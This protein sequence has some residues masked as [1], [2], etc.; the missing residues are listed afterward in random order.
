[1][2][3]TEEQRLDIIENCNRLLDGILKPFEPS[4]DTFEGRMIYQCRWL[5]ERAEN[6]DLPLPVDRGMLATLLYVYT[7]GELCNLATSTREVHAEAEVHMEKLIK[8]TKN[9]SLLLKPPY[10]PYAL[11][12]IEALRNVLHQ[13][14]RPLTQYEQGLIGELERL[15]QLLAEGKIEPPLMSYMPGYPN[16]IEVEGIE[17]ITIDDL[18]NG[19]QLYR[20]VAN[21]LFEGVRPETWFTLDNADLMTRGIRELWD[22][23]VMPRQ[24]TP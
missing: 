5:K 22:S 19:K 7:N 1:M 12:M 23:A 10:Y 9:A 16:F 24:A 21:L 11:R 17:R 4:N 20:L 13:A 8:L 2:P 15:K 14:T 3:N 18:P 6:H